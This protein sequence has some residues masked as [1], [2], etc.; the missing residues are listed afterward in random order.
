MSTALKPPS[1]SFQREIGHSEI[2]CKLAF[3]FVFEVVF[4]ELART[5][6][7]STVSWGGDR[8]VSITA[9][10]VELKELPHKEL[11][12]TCRVAEE[13]HLG[14]SLHRNHRTSN[15]PASEHNN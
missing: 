4:N 8:Q 3:R 2:L 7:G 12:P 9:V 15:K 1:F 10:H 11:D 13:K 14:P 6:C 5:S